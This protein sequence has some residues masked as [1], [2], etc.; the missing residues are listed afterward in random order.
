M[1]NVFVPDDESGFFTALQAHLLARY[2]Q[3]GIMTCFTD[4]DKLDAPAKALLTS[5]EAASG[6]GCVLPNE[7]HVA[8]FDMQPNAE[9]ID[10]FDRIN[11]SDKTVHIHYLNACDATFSKLYSRLN[12]AE[13]DGLLLFVLNL[14]TTALNREHNINYGEKG[15]IDT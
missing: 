13:R 2:W 15:E 11:K 1:L 14:L 12:A 7:R 3:A 5:L 9:I 6:S 10:G 8:F 4:R